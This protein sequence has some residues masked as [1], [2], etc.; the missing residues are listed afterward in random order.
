MSAS[1][2]V[3]KP[4]LIFKEKR[5]GRILTREFPTFSPQIVYACQDNAWMDEKAMLQWVETILTPYAPEDIIPLLLLD[6]YCCHMMATVIC[7]IQDLGVEVVHTPGGCTG[8][9]Q[10]VDVRVNKPSGCDVATSVFANLFCVLSTL[11]RTT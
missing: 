6:S 10:P 1:G 9:T 5:G 7:K 3:V 4:L 2:K 11:I 8:L